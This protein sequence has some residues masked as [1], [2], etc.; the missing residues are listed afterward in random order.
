MCPIHKDLS[1]D[2]TIPLNYRGISLLSCVRKVYSAFINKR[3]SGYLEDNN[4]LA[5]EQNSFRSNRS[6]EDHIFVSNSLIRNKAFIDIR[7]AF[8][9]IDRDMLLYKLLLNKVHTVQPTAST[10]DYCFDDRS[11]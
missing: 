7:K 4:L 1:S 3:L 5:D 6:C 2:K 10:T 8:D 11:G 9:F